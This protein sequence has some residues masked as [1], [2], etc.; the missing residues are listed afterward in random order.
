MSI[1]SIDNYSNNREWRLFE[2]NGMMRLAMS[3]CPGIGRHEGPSQRAPNSAGQV[4]Q[5][6][7]AEVPGETPDIDFHSTR[8]FT[9]PGCRKSEKT[10]LD[11][12][13]EPAILFIGWGSEATQ[14][15]PD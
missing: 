8:G 15:R 10:G 2:R 14:R 1:T 6:S 3:P 12:D 5:S 4:P 7:L 11:V 13:A 9:Q